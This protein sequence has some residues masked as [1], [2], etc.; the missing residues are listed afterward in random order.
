MVRKVRFIR[1]FVYPFDSL[2]MPP[3]LL[4]LPSFIPSNSHRYQR[5]YHGSFNQGSIGKLAL[6]Q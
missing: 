4:L 5:T 2:W 1:R 6:S 3:F